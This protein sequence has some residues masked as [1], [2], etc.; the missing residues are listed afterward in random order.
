M[1]NKSMNDIFETAKAGDL[2]KLKTFLTA[3]TINTKNSHG[4]SPLMIASL[5]GHIDLV[6]YLLDLGADPES[7]D[8]NGNTVLM[9][10]AHRG[11]VEIAMLLVKAGANPK[12]TNLRD[13]TALQFAQMFGGAEVARFLNCF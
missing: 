1:F 6:S 8:F 3:E 12:T 2:E 4:H 7:R 11:H 13:Q 9:N 10:V 5:A